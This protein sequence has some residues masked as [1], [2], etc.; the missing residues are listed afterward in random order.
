M[1]RIPQEDSAQGVARTELTGGSR[2][3]AQRYPEGSIGQAARRGDTCADYLLNRWSYLSYDVFL[4]LGFPIA[5]GVIEGVCRHLVK[6]RMDL[7]GARW[8]LQRAEAVW[9]LRSLRAGGDFEAYW[10]FHKEQERHQNHLSRY[11]D[12]LCLDAE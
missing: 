9:K 3:A 12:P 7:T 2:N 1:L 11:A 10:C 8:R 4:D 5:I 6:D